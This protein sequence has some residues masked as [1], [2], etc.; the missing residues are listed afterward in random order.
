MMGYKPSHYNKI[1]I[2]I[3][4]VYNDK[5]GTMARFAD[6][7][8]TLS[9][10]LKARL[11][12]ENDDWPIGYAISDLMWLHKETGIPLVFDFHHWKFCPGAALPDL[13]V[14]AVGRLAAVMLH[15]PVGSACEH[16]R[17]GAVHSAGM[18]MWQLQHAYTSV[19]LT[20]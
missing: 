17:A 3:G 5:Q 20:T 8:K 18:A 9:P 11:T 13:C 1:N 10:N 4:G 14:S 6:T 2:H 19:M 12:V 16:A 7:F 15:I